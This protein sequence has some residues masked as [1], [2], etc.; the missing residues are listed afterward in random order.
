MK[1]PGSLAGAD[2]SATCRTGRTRRLMKWLRNAARSAYSGASER[3]MMWLGMKHGHSPNGICSTLSQLLNFTAHKGPIEQRR[4]AVAASILTPGGLHCV[5]G[6]VRWSRAREMD[7]DAVA[8]SITNRTT[9]NPTAFIITRSVAS[10]TAHARTG[11]ALLGVIPDA[12]VTIISH[13]VPPPR[14]ANSIGATSISTTVVPAPA[15]VITSD[16]TIVAPDAAVPHHRAV[17][18]IPSATTDVVILPSRVRPHI[19]TTV[20]AARLIVIDI[21]FITTATH[22]IIAT[23]ITCTAAMVIRSLWSLWSLLVAGGF[24]E[25]VE[26]RTRGGGDDGGGP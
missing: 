19:P 14:H 17:V 7:A 26:V 10:V 18:L 2:R 15:L 20:A 24:V 9:N 1:W 21:N 5:Q 4:S 3:L 6:G 23:D 16:V 8:V 11:I 22:S 13:A 25:V 12:A